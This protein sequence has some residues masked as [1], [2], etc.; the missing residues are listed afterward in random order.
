MNI[1]TKTDVRDYRSAKPANMD[2]REWRKERDKKARVYFFHEGESIL[3]NFGN[4]AA[5]PRDLYKTYLGDVAERMGLPRDTK[6]RWSRYAGCSCPCS[7]GF[8]CDDLRG[9]K[10]FVTLSAEAP[11]VNDNAEE[12]SEAAH[13]T[14]QLV[15]QL[16]AER[17]YREPVQLSLF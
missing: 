3:E 7:P 14:M 8:I 16:A 15:G 10:A 12:L 4:R 1:K 17:A 2:G 13:R 9:V 11:K 5:R 6:F